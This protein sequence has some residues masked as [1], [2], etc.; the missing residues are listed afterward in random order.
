MPSTEKVLKALAKVDEAYRSA[1]D[2]DLIDTVG[3]LL[4]VLTEAS[5]LCQTCDEGLTFTAAELRSA[6]MEVKK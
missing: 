3:Y 1:N 6:L 4:G 5:L 2:Q